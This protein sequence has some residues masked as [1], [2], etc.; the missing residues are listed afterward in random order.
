MQITEKGKEIVSESLLNELPR[1]IDVLL[2]RR[3][4]KILF[5]DA[6]EYLTTR[7]EIEINAAFFHLLN[8]IEK[9]KLPIDL[10]KL[11]REISRKK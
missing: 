11:G 7:F 9:R 10:R 4:E 5:V 8:H 2:E 1:R 6:V 3:V